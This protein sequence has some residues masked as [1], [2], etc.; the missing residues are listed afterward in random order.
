MGSRFRVGLAARF[1]ALTVVSVLLT[2]LG[3]LFFAIREGVQSE[4]ATLLKQGKALSTFVSESTEYGIYTEDEVSLLEI[5]N[6]LA[7]NEDVVFAAILDRNGMP[8]ANRVLRQDIPSDASSARELAALPD[9][10]TITEFIAESDGLPYVE[11]VTPVF[12]N[13][14][15]DDDELFLD[16]GPAPSEKEVIGYAHLVLTTERVRQHLQD[17][18]RSALIFVPGLLFV[19]IVMTTLMMRRTTMPIRQLVLATHEISAGNLDTR[20]AIKTR[21]EVAELATSFNTMTDRL[22]EYRDEVEKAKSLLEAKVIERTLDLQKATDKAIEAA[23]R[24]EEANRAKSDFLATMSHEIRTPMNGILGMVELLLTSGLD[25]RQ[26]RSAE[27][28]QRSASV[29]LTIINDILD[30]SK[31]GAGKLQLEC[32]DFDLR[33]LLDGVLELLDNRAD[34]KGL[35]LTSRVRDDVP[36]YV[37]SDPTRLSQI[38]TNLVANAIKFTESGSVKVKARIDSTSQGKDGEECVL[39]FSV[40]DTGIGISEEARRILFEPFSQADG[41]FKRKYGGTGLGLAIASQL[42]E[43]M[44]GEI[45]VESEVGVGSTFWFTIRMLVGDASRAVGESDR[46]HLNGLHVMVVGGT[47]M[48]RK[49]FNHQLKM[50]GAHSEG[51]ANAAGAL[52]LLMNAA[53]EDPYRAALIHADLDDMSGE[54]LARTI[55]EDQGTPA[56]GAILLSATPSAEDAKTLRRR[57][58]DA[59]L[60]APTRYARLHESMLAIASELAPS[61]SADV[62]PVAVTL[63]PSN[64]TSDG[65]RVV[66]ILVAEDNPVNQEVAIG[67]LESLGC[68]VELVPDGQESVEAAG[69]GGY[70]LVFMDCQMPE[71]DGFEATRRIRT[72]EIANAPAD[73]G[74]AGAAKRT[75][76][77]ALTANAIKGDRER[78]LESGMDDYIAKPFTRKQLAEMITKWVPAAADVIPSV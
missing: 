8:L 15:S 68:S 28:V 72:Q 34:E 27:L 66:H 70:D 50:W 71:M 78:C 26:Q 25:T 54:E 41:S 53:T 3:V 76:I 57:G 40:A 9:D 58:I 1:T 51:T 60:R 49:V 2:S 43:A 10:L 24:A 69:R 19:A 12:G 38:V 44:G 59:W 20:V 14:A 23:R 4:Q 46:Q 31:I 5:I 32:V 29:L 65:R 18:V 55:R 61:Q 36:I 52:E 6:G 62:A 39:R 47:P 42:A 63:P 56:L 30:F 74:G 64:S 7:A 37:K 77:V 16:L 75:P 67:M 22:A 45:G 21:D 17:L 33:H 48:A 13:I 73:A 11:I 35:D